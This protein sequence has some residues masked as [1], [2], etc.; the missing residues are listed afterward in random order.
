MAIIPADERV[1]MVGTTTNT[2]YGG[3]QA[4]QDMQQWYTM[5]DVS[6]SVQPYKVFTA[7]LTQ[8]GE[9]GPNQDSEFPLEVGVS[10]NIFSEGAYILGDFTNVGAPNNEIGTI[11][12]ATGTT[13]NSWG[14]NISLTWDTGAPV[15]TVLENTIGNIYFQY[16]GIG[17]YTVSSDPEL[18]FPVGKTVSF[19]GSVG[20][21]PAGASYGFLRLSGGY[22]YILT[23][24]F[25]SDSNNQLNNTP[26]EIR[27]YN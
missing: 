15:A 17:Y 19:L 7:L 25:A 9:S 23:K 21:D 6:D 18:L 27:V 24:D 12:I 22:F 3:S 26:I 20:D 8:S 14:S 2:T 13:P 10:Y 1:I 5:Q 4:L 16:Q 11:F